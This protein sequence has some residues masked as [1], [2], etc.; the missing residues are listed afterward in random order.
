MP[1]LSS[2][3]AKAEGARVNY[4]TPNGRFQSL[5]TLQPVEYT[6]LPAF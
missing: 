4:F 2:D 6:Y 5:S 3:T 1:R